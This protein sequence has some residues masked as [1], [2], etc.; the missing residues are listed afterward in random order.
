MTYADESGL[1]SEP[2][3]RWRGWKHRQ[4]CGQGAVL[5]PNQSSHGNMHIIKPI[6]GHRNSGGQKPPKTQ[7]SFV[8]NLTI[9]TLATAVYTCRP[10]S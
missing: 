10:Q 7:S 2:L 6:E 3:F 8:T 1:L 5:V 9:N 4:A